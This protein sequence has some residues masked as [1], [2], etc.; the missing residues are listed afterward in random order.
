MTFLGQF[1]CKMNYCV[2]TSQRAQ[3]L[4]CPDAAN[5]AGHHGATTSASP[6][7][8]HSLGTSGLTLPAAPPTASK[9][10]FQAHGESLEHISRNSG[11]QLCQTGGK[12]QTSSSRPTIFQEQD[13]S[14]ENVVKSVF[15][16]LCNSIKIASKTNRVS[17]I[18]DEDLSLEITKCS[19]SN[20]FS[21]VLRDKR[22]E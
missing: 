3:D 2:S 21:S 8:E 5:H 9:R 4:V 18:L 15:A 16:G 12:G 6:L 19:D 10:L 20:L 11:A 17:G 22:E 7:S 1:N 13:V 14:W